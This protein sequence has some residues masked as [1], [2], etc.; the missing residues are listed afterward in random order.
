MAD[1]NSS[2][3]D[4]VD[5]SLASI[6]MLAADFG[7]GMLGTAMNRRALVSYNKEV[8]KLGGEFRPIFASERQYI[9]DQLKGSKAKIGGRFTPKLTSGRVKTI[10]GWPGF[11]AGVEDIKTTNSTYWIRDRIHGFASSAAQKLEDI[12]GFRP[13]KSMGIGSSAEIHNDRIIR[14]FGK[15]LD[16]RKMSTNSGRAL[17]S[18][19]QAGNALRGF[20]S[21]AFGV[22]FANAGYQMAAGSV[23]YLESRGQ[24]VKNTT[25]GID[26]GKGFF[27]TRQSYTMR[28]RGLQSIHNS[29]LGVRRAL[30]NEAGFIHQYV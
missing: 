22:A 7:L 24:R 4:R 20:G 28:Q 30:G 13:F 6:P 11:M 26:M 21:F 19:L 16:P 18:T 9:H 1:H 2:F 15:S 25:S 12:T 29:Q 5:S 10:V 27:D 23:S 17:A 14:D 3:M 8:S